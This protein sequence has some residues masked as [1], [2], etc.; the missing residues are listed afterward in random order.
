MHT[1]S[2]GTETHTI[3]EYPIVSAQTHTFEMETKEAIPGATVVVLVVGVMVVVVV[4]HPRWL[5]PVAA[6]T[7][8]AQQP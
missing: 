3:D 7:P 4:G 8:S 5:G 2:L 6:V 1:L